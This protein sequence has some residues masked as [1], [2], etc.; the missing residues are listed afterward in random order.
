MSKAAF[1]STPTLIVQFQVVEILIENCDKFFSNPLLGSDSSPDVTRNSDVVDG[2]GGGGG[3]ADTPTAPMTGP[4]INR[5]RNKKPREKR[6]SSTPK[7]TQS[8]SSFS[9]LSTSSLPDIKE[10]K[11]RALAALSAATSRNNSHHNNSSSNTSNNEH[12]KVNTHPLNIIKNKN[13]HYNQV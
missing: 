3:V 7:R 4:A 13:L 12:N 9:Q 2:G 8:F 5:G 11:D 10:F 1:M 6:G